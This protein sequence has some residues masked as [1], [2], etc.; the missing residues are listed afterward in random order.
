[1]QISKVVKEYA[2]CERHKGEIT[3]E[4]TSIF[5]WRSTT[6]MGYRGFRFAFLELLRITP[7]QVISLI[8]ICGKIP[9]LAVPC[10]RTTPIDSCLSSSAKILYSRVYQS[11]LPVATEQG[12]HADGDTS[13]KL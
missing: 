9:R 5:A 7:G 6:V 1:M 10:P 2:P 11:N 13:V 12:L 8:A 4:K 3:D